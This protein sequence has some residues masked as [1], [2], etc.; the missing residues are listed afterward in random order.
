MSPLRCSMRHTYLSAFCQ[1]SNAMPQP[2]RRSS[3][4]RPY[5]A[6]AALTRCGMICISGCTLTTRSGLNCSNAR[7]TWHFCHVR[8]SIKLS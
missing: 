8:H 5:R 6:R 3:C 4:N 2:G 1:A 7:A